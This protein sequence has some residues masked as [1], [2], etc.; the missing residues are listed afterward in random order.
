[1]AL[2]LAW[3]GECGRVYNPAVCFAFNHWADAW[4]VDA[5]R[6]VPASRRL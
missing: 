4:A 3:T 2:K 6:F 5:C 1:M